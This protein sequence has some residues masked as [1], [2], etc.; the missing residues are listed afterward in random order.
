MKE[1]YKFVLCKIRMTKTYQ[2]K[3]AAKGEELQIMKEQERL[4]KI[5][6]GPQDF[7]DGREKGWSC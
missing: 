2:V 3:V 7:I 1:T 5:F 4:S 6:H